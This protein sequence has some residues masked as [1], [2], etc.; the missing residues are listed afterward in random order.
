VGNGED[1]VVLFDITDPVHPKELS[2]AR[3]HTAQVNMVAFSPDGKTLASGSADD[4]TR[5]WDVSDPA[6]PVE[7]ANLAFGRSIFDLTFSADGR[8]LLPVY[9]GTTVVLFDR[10]VDEV[11]D[12]VCRRI[13]TPI[14]KDQWELDLPKTAYKPPCPVT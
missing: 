13:G 5:L 8:T 14:T 2:T 12:A 6:K 3:A 11:I 4:S 1:N 7:T 10:D 9:D